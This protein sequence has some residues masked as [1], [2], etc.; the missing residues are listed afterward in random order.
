MVTGGDSSRLEECHLVFNEDKDKLATGTSVP[1]KVVEQTILSIFS[2]G[3][4]RQA[5]EGQEG[6]WEKSPCFYEWESFLTNP[7]DF[8]D[9][10]L[11]S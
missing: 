9:D 1:G 7:K 2:K 6:D 4:Q 3:R 5:Y 10:R 11:P 8:C